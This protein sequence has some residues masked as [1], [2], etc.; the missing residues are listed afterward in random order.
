MIAQL[1]KPIIYLI[2]SGKTAQTTTPKDE[3]FIN[4]LK[5]IERAVSLNISLI[6]IREKNL[7]AN[8]LYQLAVQ[9]IKLTKNSNTRLLINDRTDIALAASADGVHLTTTSLPTNLIRQTFGKDLIIGASSHSIEEATRALNEGADFTT[10]GPIF[11]T[12]SKRTYGPSLGPEKLSEVVATVSPFPVIALGG[13]SINNIS[14]VMHTG[15]AG[16]AAI[17]LLD[18]IDK[19][20]ETVQ[21]IKRILKTTIKLT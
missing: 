2:T 18:N 5:L 20:A 7:N 13:I 1:Q 17:R 9:A 16:I 4:I 19:M 6:Q 10:F 14:D 8:I 21:T 12:P 3:P 11:D 15:A